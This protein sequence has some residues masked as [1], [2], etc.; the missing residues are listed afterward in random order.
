MMEPSETHAK[1]ENARKVR[2]LTYHRVGLPRGG[3]TEPLTVPP[4]RFA[5]QMRMLRRL[6]YAAVG[7]DEVAGWL[8]GAALPARVAALTFDDGYGDLYESV[9]PLLAEMK[10]SATIYVVSDMEDAAWRRDS[11]PHP[12]PL[13]TAAQ[14]REMAAGGVTFGSHTRTHRRLTECPPPEL[15]EEVAGSRK[16]IED[17]LGREVRHFCYPYGAFDDRVVDAVRDAG[18]R[19]AVTTV[20]DS[21]RPGADPLRLPRWNV[22]R[23]AGMIKFFLRLTLRS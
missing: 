16:K 2:I 6:G 9:F 10:L 5:R 18:Y 3:R 17:V 19:T 4:D 20:K 7:M 23:R 14:M 13:L 21:V 11:S 15:R 12:L 8:G 22:G 1:A